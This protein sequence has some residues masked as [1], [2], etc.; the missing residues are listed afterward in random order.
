MARDATCWS[1]SSACAARWTS[2]SATSGARAAGCPAGRRPGFSP[3]VDVY[4]CGDP[5]KA[6]VK[7][8]LAGVSLDTVSLEIVG[9]ELVIR[10]ERPVQET[11]GRVYQ[12]V[13]IEAGP[14]RRVVE[15]NADVVAEEATATYED[16]V[17]RVELPLRASGQASR[18]RPDRDEGVGLMAQS[19]M[20]G[21]TIEVVE[22]PDVEEAIRERQAQPLPAA[23]PVLPLKE[24]VPYP[25]TLTPLAVGQQRS[26]RL[27]NDVLS[28]ERMLVLVASRDP[29][30]DEPGP[31][32][33][34]DV[35]VAG[36]VARMLKVPDGTIRI[37]V[38]GTERVRW[39]TTSPRSPTSWRG[40]SRCPT[41]SSRL[42]SS[43][44]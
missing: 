27:V 10:G 5:P 35:G 20:A 38:Q 28:G 3:R 26:I 4:Y 11:E 37:L 23:L 2:C 40:S 33:L 13:E 9:R 25:D 30:V 44:R 39:A 42:P 29:E 32:Q 12:Q 22:T 19:G 16:G 36:I 7:A 31:D 41:W 14:F 15:L 34:Y 6:V 43:R 8:E 18:Q 1:T 21:P 17:L 24:M